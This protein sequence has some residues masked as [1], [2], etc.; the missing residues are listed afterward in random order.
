[1]GLSSDNWYRN[2]LGGDL[3]SPSVLDRDIA[4][5]NGRK[6]T[7]FR[8]ATVPADVAIAVR[9]Y[10]ATTLDVTTAAMGNA[11]TSEVNRLT[12]VDDDAID[13]VLD[14]CRLPRLFE[15]AAAV[16]PEKKVTFRAS[17]RSGITSKPKAINKAKRVG[18][19]SLPP[20]GGV[21]H[22]RPQGF[23]VKFLFQPFVWPEDSETLLNKDAETLLDE[24]KLFE[25]NAMDA[26][27]AANGVLDGGSWVG[28]SADG[29]RAAYSEAVSL[30][31]H[32]AAPGNTTLALVASTCSRRDLLNLE[33]RTSR[34]ALCQLAP[35]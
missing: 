4:C 22:P 2:G 10:I 20:V 14:V 11:Q 3:A 25:D 21:D 31:F 30:K 6:L 19:P 9:K 27:R 15:M 7:P 35:Y 13:A 18:T 17:G 26:R 5:V 1:M 8:R 29:A 32:Q 33:P 24:S 34:Q 16:N 12:D 23:F 28:K